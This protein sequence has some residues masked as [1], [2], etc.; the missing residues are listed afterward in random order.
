MVWADAHAALNGTTNTFVCMTF[1]TF[2]N[3]A[4]RESTLPSAA[5]AVPARANTHRAQTDHA[6]ETAFDFVKNIY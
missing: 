5:P 6:C 4:A 1:T 3:A 2:V